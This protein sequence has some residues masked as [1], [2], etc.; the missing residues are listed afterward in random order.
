MADD[1]TPFPS[2]RKSVPRRLRF[3]ILR[4][5]EYTCRYCGAS[6]PHA[7]LTIDHVVPVALGGGDDPSNLV[8]ACK[9]CNAGKGSTSPD[10]KI[11]EDVDAAALLL[12]RALERA[13]EIRRGEISNF[14]N[15]CIRFRTEW[16]DIWGSDRNIPYTFDASLKSFLSRGL[17]PDEVI[18]YI[19][20]TATSRVTFGDAFRYFCGCCWR[21]IGDREELARRLIEEGAV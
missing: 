18:R 20:V 10:E 7:T 8:T 17:T 11:V 2:A 4:R 16:I 15:I 13:A 19:A 12:S 5:D 9:D 21:E 1:G 6:A 3:E 14:D